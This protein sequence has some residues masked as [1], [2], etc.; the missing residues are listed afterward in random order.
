MELHTHIL[1]LEKEL[2]VLNTIQEVNKALERLRTAIETYEAMGYDINNYKPFADNYP[3][4]Q[5]IWSFFL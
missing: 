1:K 3:F 2:N 5:D 4:K